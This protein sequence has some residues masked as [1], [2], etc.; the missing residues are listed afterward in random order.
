MA[1]NKKSKMKKTYNKS[2]KKFS[3]K[4]PLLI[5]V[6]VLVVAVG[7][8][9]IIRSFAAPVVGAIEGE[10]LIGSGTVV[11]DSSAGGMKALK[12][13][14]STAASGTVDVKA[15]SGTVNVTATGDRLEVRAKGDQCSGSPTM[16]VN[17]DGKDVMTATV[18]GT[19]WG[20]YGQSFAIAAG[21]HTVSVRMTNPYTGFKGKSRNIACTRALY[22]DS[23]QF[24]DTTTVTPPAIDATA[25]ATSITNL[26]NG[27]SVS[28][29]AAV[30]AS[31]SDNVGVTK[32]E[33]YIDS[34]LYGVAVTATPYNWSWDTTAYA[35]GSHSLYTK[36]Y[37]SANNASTSSTITVTVNNAKTGLT[38]AER[39]GISTGWFGGDYQYGG[40]WL[41]P[42]VDNNLYFSTIKS[43]GGKWART[44]AN[45]SNGASA[46]QNEGGLKSI[47]SFLA[48]ARN[49]GM[50][51]LVTFTYGDYNNPTA[52]VGTA[53]DYIAHWKAIGLLDAVG[54]YEIWNEPNNAFGTSGIPYLSADAYAKLLKSVYPSI[55]A[56]DPNKPVVSGGMS[57]GRYVNGPVGAKIPGT[58]TT[59]L[60][61][62]AE[63][64]NNIY[65]ANGG[66]S[67]GL[68]DAVGFH[69]Y[70]LGSSSLTSG[71]LGGSAFRATHFIRQVMNSRGDN[72]KKIWGTEAGLNSC[73]S[74]YGNAPMTEDQRKTRYNN[75]MYDWFYGVH[76]V[77]SGKLTSYSAQSDWGTEMYF[78][79]KPFKAGMAGSADPS[80]DNFGVVY[81][82]STAP[83]GCAPYGN[84]YKPPM[85][86]AIQTFTSSLQSTV[87]TAPIP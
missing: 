55:K 71:N 66:T 41:A 70:T 81:T 46:T 60:S 78:L 77:A 87:P 20:P 12:L 13:T 85:F 42:N 19:T 73:G 82:G 23:I 76:D 32:V 37:D 16:V 52:W 53:N 68:F 48:G 15:T 39:F 50:K 86:G 44:D 6:I 54:A 29:V 14:N 17:V 75:D 31:A 84:G 59:D 72:S 3:F 47:D 57:S 45:I 58:T 10:A 26:A 21:T 43:M 5:A 35:D 2:I 27:G 56:A 65:I 24:L 34:K 69:P 64:L 25:P 80:A 22:V 74:A 11:S 1:K 83:Y 18:S 33:L 79:F 7:V 67:N 38:N 61:N 51:V 62:P 30:T 63:Y 28:G 40:G 9:L 36:A 8:F 4:N 49:N